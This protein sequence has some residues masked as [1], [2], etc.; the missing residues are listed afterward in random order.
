MKKV[1]ILCVCG[2]GTV[3]SAMVASKLREQLKEKGFDADT[4]ETSP[5]GIES[6]ISGTHFDLIACVSPVYTDYGIP[7]VNAVGML[8]GLG[9]EKVVDDCVAI[10]KNV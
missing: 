3:S 7:K 10:L 2:S 5:N 6:E 1:K 8:T 4:V 9:E